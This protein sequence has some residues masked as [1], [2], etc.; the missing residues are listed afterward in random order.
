MAAR[1]IYLKAQIET[2]SPWTQGFEILLE[3][4]GKLGL[5]E[6]AT[7]V[8][9]GGSCIND[10]KQKNDVHL[11]EKTLNKVR[12]ALREAVK[13]MEYSTESVEVF[14]DGLVSSMENYGIL[15][16]ERR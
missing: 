13:S 6:G 14:V 5:V 11:D 3:A 10:K 9:L 15:F 16:L 1:T 12:T 8:C 7:F 4:G 2:G